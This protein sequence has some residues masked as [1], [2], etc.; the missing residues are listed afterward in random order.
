MFDIMVSLFWHL[1]FTG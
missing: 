1:Y